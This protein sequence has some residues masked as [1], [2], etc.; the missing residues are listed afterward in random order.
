M[1]VTLP[2]SMRVSTIHRL[3]QDVDIFETRVESKS[4]A[5]S[6]TKKKDPPSRLVSRCLPPGL[7]NGQRCILYSAPARSERRLSFAPGLD[8]VVLE[9]VVRNRQVQGSPNAPASFGSLGRVGVE[10]VR[11]TVNYY[12]TRLLKY[13]SLFA[14]QR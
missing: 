2:T 14:R 6:V 10:P 8:C 13:L 1:S 9:S 7:D 3:C 5:N 4:S 11:T 12:L